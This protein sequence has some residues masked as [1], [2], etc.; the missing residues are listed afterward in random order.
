MKFCEECGRFISSHHQQCPYCEMELLRKVE[1]RVNSKEL[2]FRELQVG[3]KLYTLKGLIK[4]GGFGYVFKGQESPDG[5]EVALKLPFRLLAAQGKL[6][7]LPEESL[8]ASEE[9]IE[10]EIENLKRFHHPAI[11]RMLHWGRVAVPSEGGEVPVLV[12]ELASGN[13]EE[14][15]S[16]FSLSLEERLK[17]VRAAVDALAYLHQQGFVYRDMSLK[18]ILMVEREDGEVH[19][20]LADFGASKGLVRT[21]DG[22]TRAIGTQRY[23]HPSYLLNPKEWSRDPRIDVFSLAVVILELIIGV[24]NWTKL[25]PDEDV[26]T[27]LDKPISE[28][29]I[30][31]RKEGRIPGELAELLL[32]STSED[33]ED[34]PASAN[35]FKEEFSLLFEST[36]V[37]APPPEEY[38]SRRFEVPF[39]VKIKLPLPQ[40]WEERTFKAEKKEAKEGKVLFLE[41]PRGVK[42]TLPFEMSSRAR[43]EIV[44]GP[45]FYEVIK[46]DSRTLYLRLH[47]SRLRY[48]LKAF[49]EEGFEIEGEMEFYGKILVED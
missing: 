5:S 45:P 27:P 3:E 4:S 2:P 28:V 9:S 44:D 24:P 30:Q 47:L 36:L 25:Y 1:L 19:P 43:A 8:K 12:L 41:D 21:S 22:S 37:S 39:A 23:M 14:L 13:V 10:R 42:I 33:I 26:K 31:Q 40:D 6:Y 18:N 35:E 17:I 20:V 7:G 15:M 48:E 29:I 16:A 11:I 32:R 34:I 46:A 49:R 38:V